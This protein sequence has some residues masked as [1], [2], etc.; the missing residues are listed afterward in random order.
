MNRVTIREANEED[1]PRLRTMEQGVVEAE[2][3]YNSLLRAGPVNYY[4]IGALIASDKSM[5]LVADHVGQ[6]VGSGYATLKESLP[7]L[8]HERH[9][10]LG[11]MYVDPNFRGQGVIQ[12][13]LD[14]LVDW[15]RGRGIND[16]YLDVYAGNVA[17]I[18][19][20][21]KYGF[22]S[23]LIEMKLCNSTD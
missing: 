22:R 20:Y 18:K 16:F 4:D 15:S 23:N 14:G 13:I 10:Y 1:V 8:K 17:A 2:R 19:A 3:P 5:V 21:E 7:Y 6:V 9:S 12:Q 11:F